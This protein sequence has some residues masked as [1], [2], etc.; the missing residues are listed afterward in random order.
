MLSVNDHNY[1]VLQ[2]LTIKYVVQINLEFVAIFPGV[3]L[4]CFILACQINCLNCSGMNYSARSIIFTY[5][6]LKVTYLFNN[7][8]PIYCH[9]GTYFDSPCTEIGSRFLE[10]VYQ[11]CAK[12]FIVFWLKWNAKKLKES[13]PFKD[14][15]TWSTR[16]V[17][18]QRK[19]GFGLKD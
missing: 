3:K 18:K 16:D 17:Q 6:A 14:P 15:K 5:K 11:H 12:L 8:L 7:L 13:W 10:L 1:E 19:F 4:S 9:H 2:L